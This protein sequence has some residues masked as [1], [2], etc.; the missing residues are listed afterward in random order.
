MMN[1]LKSNQGLSRIE[2]ICITGIIFISLF[3]A[4]SV[5]NWYHVSQLK[6]EDKIMANTAKRVAE[7][8]TVG[9]PCPVHNC[10]GETRCTHKTEE[11]YVGYFDRPTNA[12]YGERKKGYNQ[13][14]EIKLSGKTYTGEAGTLVIKVVCTDGEIRLSWEKGRRK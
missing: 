1:K 12:I 11:G 5:L 6:A 3:F 10:D 7:M 8:N 14:R 13:Y 4:C 2:L 9:N